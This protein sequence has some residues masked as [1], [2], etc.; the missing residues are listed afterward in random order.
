MLKNKWITT[1][2]AGTQQGRIQDFVL[3]GTKVGEG[4]GDRLRSPAGSVLV[5]GH[6]GGAPPP[7]GSSWVLSIQEVFP[8]TILKHFVNVMKCIKTHE[9]SPKSF[10]VSTRNRCGHF[11]LGASCIARNHGYFCS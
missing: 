7:T 11:E 1:K 3:G 10:K 9:S 8:S 4:S 6:G 5:G 2:I